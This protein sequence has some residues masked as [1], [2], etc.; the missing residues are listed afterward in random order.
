MP[1]VTRRT[2]VKTSVIA[3]GGALA[4]KEFLFGGLDTLAFESPLA[5]EA[6][7]RVTD[8]VPTTCWIGKQDCGMLAHCV[9]GRE[10]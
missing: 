9:D 5:I 7:A 3:T 4:A 2:F 8:V 6:Q 1:P 10:T